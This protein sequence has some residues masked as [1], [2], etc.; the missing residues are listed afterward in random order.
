M[1]LG[2]SPIVYFCR[3]MLHPHVGIPVAYKAPL[4]LAPTAPH[5]APCLASLLL[6]EL[7]QAQ[8]CPRAFALAFPSAQDPPPL[9]ILEAYSHTLHLVSIFLYHPI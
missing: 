2:F 3:Y 7:Q 6:L 8:C 1:A 4:H 9:E 5:A